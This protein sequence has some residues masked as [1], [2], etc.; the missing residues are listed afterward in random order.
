M[1]EDGPSGQ[2]GLLL[3]PA[4]GGPLVPV[5][6]KARPGAGE[7]LAA[8]R[9]ELVLAHPGHQSIVTAVGDVCNPYVRLGMS[10]S[11]PTNILGRTREPDGR[12][13]RR[14][15]GHRGERDQVPCERV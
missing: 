14:A 8:A 13:G 9:V 10:Q 3:Q 1:V 15:A 7:D 4:D 5:A 6:G 11:G 2:A 12:A